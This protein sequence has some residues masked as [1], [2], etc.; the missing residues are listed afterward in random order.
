MFEDK[1]GLLMRKDPSRIYA[2]LCGQKPVTRQRL[3]GA[4]TGRRVFELTTLIA[5]IGAT[6]TSHF[7]LPDWRCRLDLLLEPIRYLLEPAKPMRLRIP[8]V[9]QF[10][11]LHHCIRLIAPIYPFS[12]PPATAR[13]TYVIQHRDCL[14]YMLTL[15]PKYHN[16]E[17]E[18]PFPIG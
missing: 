18:I 13:K 8:A 2:N 16:P 10:S 7:H 17:L 14:S 5:V 1:F 12:S 15:I 3:L 6:L 4:L 9:I 11:E